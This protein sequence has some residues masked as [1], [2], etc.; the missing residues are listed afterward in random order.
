MFRPK[1][2]VLTGAAMVA[3]LMILFP[4]YWSALESGTTGMGDIDN[5]VVTTKFAGYGFLFAGSE[6]KLPF[7]SVELYCDAG[8][9]FSVLGAQLLVVA[10]I[11]A[12]LWRIDGRTKRA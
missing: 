1:I 6:G 10:A 5:S 8:I 11:A 3:V 9:F 7:C 4:P 2:R 12:Y